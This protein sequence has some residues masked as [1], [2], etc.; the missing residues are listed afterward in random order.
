MSLE[1]LDVIYWVQYKQYNYI[2]LQLNDSLEA[3]LIP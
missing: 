1:V 3:I 2:S